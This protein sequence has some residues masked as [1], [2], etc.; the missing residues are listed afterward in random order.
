VAVYHASRFSAHLLY[1]RLT[2]KTD[3]EHAFECVMTCEQDRL[4]LRAEDPVH[5]PFPRL[6]CT[7]RALAVLCEGKCASTDRTLSYHCRFI[8]Y[9][10]SLKLRKSDGGPSQLCWA[11]SSSKLMHQYNSIRAPNYH[12][13]GTVVESA[14][15]LQCKYTAASSKVYNGVIISP[16]Q[17]LGIC[18]VESGHQTICQPL[19]SSL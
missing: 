17:V 16:K 4:E 6:R 19:S 3:S 13:H 11:G 18:F 15:L 8:C 5:H 10:S 7:F 9:A 12:C 1:A 2:V 14:K